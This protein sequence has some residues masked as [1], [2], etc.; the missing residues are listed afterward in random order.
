M[1]G[2]GSE[3]TV[4][5]TAG[6][7]ANYPGVVYRGIQDRDGPTL[8]GYSAYWRP[9]NEN[10]SLRRFLKFVQHRYALSFSI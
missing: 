8:V 7:G 9:R 3:V 5:N 1:I 2:R 10:P 6:A 4:L